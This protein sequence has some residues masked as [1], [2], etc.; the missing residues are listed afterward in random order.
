M[1]DLKTGPAHWVFC[2]NELLVLIWILRHAKLDIFSG[3]AL[4]QV[5]RITK[6]E[7][8]GNVWLTC[9]KSKIR[10]LG[11]P[12]KNEPIDRRYS[13]RRS[14]FDFPFGPLGGGRGSI[15]V[16]AF[17]EALDGGGGASEGRKVVAKGVGAGA[18]AREYRN[19]R[20]ACFLF[21]TGCTE[22]LVRRRH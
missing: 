11:P 6:Y 8:F 17:D 18:D 21:N 16:V 5:E 2:E 12:E 4:E 7:M 15:G 13:R 10:S 19:W 22:V 3:D 20:E 14:A 9:V 1:H